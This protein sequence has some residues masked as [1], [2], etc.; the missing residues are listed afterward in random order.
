MVRDP[1]EAA[2]AVTGAAAA[3]T[4]MIASTPERT[5]AVMKLGPLSFR[6]YGVS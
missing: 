2:V 4:A 5:R 1:Y 3:A 6:A